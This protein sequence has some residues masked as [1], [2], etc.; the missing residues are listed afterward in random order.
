VLSTSEVETLLKHMGAH[1]TLTVAVAIPIPGLR[2]AARFIWTFTFRL[3][4][5]Y[6]LG[7]GR[8]TREEYQVARSIH[9]VPVMILALVPA[10]GAMAYAASDTLLKRGLGR[11]LLDQSAHKVPLGLY[12]RLGLGRIIAPRSPEPV[13][14][15]KVNVASGGLVLPADVLIEPLRVRIE[16]QTQLVSRAVHE[17]GERGYEWDSLRTERVD[18]GAVWVNS[19]LLDRYVGNLER[20]ASV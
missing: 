18:F 4:A 19:S 2:S 12:S 7:R 13:V 16:D 20:T 9:S 5:L 8:M 10:L 14:I 17:K 6:E 3:K 11:M 15:R 1:L